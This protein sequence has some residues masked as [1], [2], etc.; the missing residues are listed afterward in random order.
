M[1]APVS[2]PGYKLRGDCP[3]SVSL[4]VAGESKSRVCRHEAAF[5]CYPEYCNGIDE[6]GADDE[7]GGVDPV[8]GALGPAYFGNCELDVPAVAL[9]G[10]WASSGPTTHRA[11]A[12]TGGAC[13]KIVHSV[14]SSTVYRETIHFTFPSVSTYNTVDKTLGVDENATA[15]NR[16]DG[17]SEHYYSLD[18]CRQR[19]P[20][21]A[22]P[23]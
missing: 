15:G 22:W 23:V 8:R 6:V 21:H 20:H 12:G 14:P 17:A 13:L 2:P 18:H 4:Q 7:G 10:E 19:R 11:P 9:E 5:A 1:A 16:G 3:R